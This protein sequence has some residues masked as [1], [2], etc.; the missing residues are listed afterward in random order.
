MRFECSDEQR[1]LIFED[2]S[3]LENSN[4]KQVEGW[5][6]VGEQKQKRSTNKSPASIAVS[7]EPRTKESIML[8]RHK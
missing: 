1:K 5:S 4:S 7:K 8:T 3:E 6:F 2:F